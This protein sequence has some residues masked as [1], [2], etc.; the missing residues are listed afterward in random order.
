MTGSVNQE[1]LKKY[2]ALTF[3]TQAGTRIHS[4]EEAV[5]FVNQRGFVFFWPIKEIV[6]PSL[7]GAVAGDRATQAGQIGRAHV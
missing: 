6:L 7:W 4:K 2:R 5:E 3:R 1:A